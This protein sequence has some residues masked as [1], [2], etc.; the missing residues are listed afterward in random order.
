MSHGHH[1]NMHSIL[2]GF[3]KLHIYIFIE[4]EREEENETKK[5][6]RQKEIY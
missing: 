2:L 5:I 1:I 6:I 3:V 4:R